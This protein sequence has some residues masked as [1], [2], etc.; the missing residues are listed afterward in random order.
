MVLPKR[1]KDEFYKSKNGKYGV[2]AICKICSSKERKQYHI[3]HRDE[4][5]RRG[6]EWRKNNYE[7]DRKMKYDYSRTARGIYCQIKNKGKMGLR[8]NMEMT[9][10]EFEKWYNATEEVCEYCGLTLEQLKQMKCR[11]SMKL[12]RM[13]VDRKDS[14]QNYKVGNVVKA[15]MKC[16]IVKLDLFTHEQMK[17]IGKMLRTNLGF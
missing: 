4:E 8:Y 10:E 15:C 14:L 12:K 2:Y 7:K 3:D 9:V 13:T 11:Y 16:N 1:V 17:T 5:L 6:K